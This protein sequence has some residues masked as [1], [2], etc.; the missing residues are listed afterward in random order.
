MMVMKI[1]KQ[2]LFLPTKNLIQW[3]LNHLLEVEK[4]TFLFF[5]MQSHFVVPIN[6]RLKFHTL[7]CCED[8]K[9]AR[10]SLNRV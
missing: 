6:T 4:E 10:A 8:S 7:F 1:K 3:Q 2:I 5:I 9:Q